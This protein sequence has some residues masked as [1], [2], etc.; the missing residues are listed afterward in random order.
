LVRQNASTITIVAFGLVAAA[1][2]LPLSLGP[3][4][5][6]FQ[7]DWLWPADR[8][9]CN[10]YALFGMSPWLQ[11]GAGMPAIYP[12]FWAPYAASG[13][14]CDIAG[15][16]LGLG[17]FLFGIMA[18]GALGV[19]YL[20]RSLGATSRYVAA[21]AILL[22]WGNPVVL[23]E[24]HAGHLFFLWSYALLPAL[25]GITLCKKQPFSGFCAGALLGLASAQQQFFA[26]GLLAMAVLLIAN[27]KRGDWRFFAVA[28]AIGL[29]VTSPM[30][31]LA[32]VATPEHIL[33]PQHPQLHWELS[34]S[35]PFADAVRLIGYIGHYDAAI[36]PLS[37]YALFLT[38]I[39]ALVAALTAQRHRR[40]AYALAAL[41]VGAVTICWGLDGPLAGILATAF[42]RVPAFALFREFYNFAGLAQ[43][44]FVALIA[45]WLSGAFEH[46]GLRPVAFAVAVVV[47]ANAAYIA[48]QTSIGIP[49]AT[50]S[51]T[52]RETMRELAQRKTPGRFITVPA[53][54]PQSLRSDETHSGFSPWT[55]PIGAQSGT[56]VP[57]APFPLVFAAHS[58]DASRKARVYE[59]LGVDTTVPIPGVATNLNFEPA[60]RALEPPESLNLSGESRAERFEGNSLVAV[61]TFSAGLGTIDSA[62][63][64]ARDIG[65][66]G[67]SARQV[68]V[69]DGVGYNPLESWAPLS[70]FPGLESWL[71]VL[72]SGIVTMRDS[73]PLPFAA[74]FVVA[75]S[76]D[77]AI[78]SNACLQTARIDTHF[79]LYRCNGLGA[80][81]RGK[82][83]L[84]VSSAGNG[85]LVAER[86]LSGA[87]GMVNVEYWTPWRIVLH[88]QAHRGSAL[89]LRE[90][91]D[92]AWRCSGC[93]DADH[94]ILDGYA[95]GWVFQ[96]GVD[97]NVTLYFED[98]AAYFVCL[99]LSIALLSA[100][101]IGGLYGTAQYLASRKARS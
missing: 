10:S 96:T 85:P 94:R 75:G 88:I 69:V 35:A 33:G 81:L 71:Y 15:P 44:C 34:Q 90:T 58:L 84:V 57:L 29:G 79:A 2:I 32:V 73:A 3:G 19:A 38:P 4:V 17:L 46:R 43:T 49:S 27:Y 40:A 13:I 64:G 14:L 101:A 26:I 76:A 86:K 45:V 9:Q 59:R 22:F 54:V 89:I 8:V 28:L 47:I 23:N 61:E 87:R 92:S 12:Q 80:W 78:R 91:Y 37:S 93:G 39:I 16:Q 50:L 72:P 74:T 25:M 52:E 1:V 97:R 67:S 66:F 36:S 21:V 20:C 5:P 53:V 7:H 98:A 100:S 82:P 55:I 63:S 62:Y 24:V 41:M 48:T 6:A 56:S 70:L 83:P 51:A 11:N 18:I 77:G 30:W 65:P 95:N 42:D 60:L 31:I 99:A 68:S